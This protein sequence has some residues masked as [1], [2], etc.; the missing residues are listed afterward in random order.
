MELLEELLG[1]VVLTGPL[2]L[3]VLWL[4]VSIWASFKIARKL[5]GGKAKTLGALLAFL[6]VFC[7]PFV[8]EIAGRIYLGYLCK[9]EAGMKV[10]QTVTLPDK[11]WDEHGE[12]KFIRGGGL[13]TEMLPEYGTNFENTQYPSVFSIK[14]FRFWYFSKTTD[15]ILGEF[16][17]FNFRGGWIVRA[18][19]PSG[20]SGSS[21][22][23]A[24][25]GRARDHVLAIFKPVS[26]SS[27]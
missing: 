14:K 23:Q 9:A 27:N 12:P 3:I 24:T 26:L 20:G 17:N 19:S 18:F 21:C 13:D 11:Y 5:Q 25:V 1:F 2:L 10:F 6:L 4:P 8:D 7:L 22:N 16:M 15:E